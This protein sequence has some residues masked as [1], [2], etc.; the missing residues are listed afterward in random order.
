[1]IQKYPNNQGVEYWGFWNKKTGYDVV[2]PINQRILKYIDCYGK[3][4]T[5]FKEND[6]VILNKQIKE[7]CEIAGIDEVIKSRKSQ[8]VIVNGK[9][10][11]R[12]ISNT[13]KKFEII[14]NHSF[15]RSFATNYIKV[16]GAYNVRAVTGHK[17]D[18]MLYNY[19]NESSIN[20]DQ[21]SQMLK[22]MNENAERLEQKQKKPQLN[23]V[24]R[25]SS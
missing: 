14:T 22:G 4:K 3:P 21:I 19:I 20:D 1:M 2:L 16:I 25:A 17:S 18:E 13:Y 11:R 9:S 23:I 6:N 7:I 24:K 12:S 8:S 15:R 5:T 10:T